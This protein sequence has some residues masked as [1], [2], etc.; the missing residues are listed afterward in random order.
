M[1]IALVLTQHLGYSGTFFRSKIKGLIGNGHRVI[2]VPARLAGRT[3]I[4]T[5][6]A[7]GWGSKAWV[8]RS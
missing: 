6:K 3:F 8:W 2:L 1:T 7:T 4:Y 5:N